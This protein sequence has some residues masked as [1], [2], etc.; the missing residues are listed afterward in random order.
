MES[1]RALPG[2]GRYLAKCNLLIAR[3]WGLRERGASHIW[4]TPRSHVLYLPAAA[5]S[6]FGS[7][8]SAILSS[9]SSDEVM[10]AMVIWYNLW[11]HCE[12]MWVMSHCE[13]GIVAF[14]LWPRPQRGSSEGFDCSPAKTQQWHLV[15]G[16]FSWQ[17]WRLMALHGWFSNCSLMILG[18]FS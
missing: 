10:L 18:F 7:E 6:H 13:S 8:H 11:S 4:R 5:A 14:W 2:Q 9:C 15:E 16:L 12:S 1:S 3:S 17:S